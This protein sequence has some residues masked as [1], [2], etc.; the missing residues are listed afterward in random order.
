MNIF[1]AGGAIK[2]RR[3]GG[4]ATKGIGLSSKRFSFGSKKNGLLDLLVSYGLGSVGT[5]CKCCS[6]V[7]TCYHTSKMRNNSFNML[8]LLDKGF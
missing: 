8:L 6:F 7:V 3:I 2:K 5:N 1:D 4:C